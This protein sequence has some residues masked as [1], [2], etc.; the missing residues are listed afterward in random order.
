MRAR[1]R[2]LD[3]R[4]TALSDNLKK[5]SRVAHIVRNV[6][7]EHGNTL[8]ISIVRDGLIPPVRFC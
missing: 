7:H 6:L 5:R 2:Y 4:R 3:L 1:Y 8:L